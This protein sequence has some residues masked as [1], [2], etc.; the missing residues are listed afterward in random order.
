MT[1]T[2]ILSFSQSP[3]LLA[4]PQPEDRVSFACI[5]IFLSAS[6]TPASV[7]VRDPRF[8]PL[9]GACGSPPLPPGGGVQNS[10]RVSQQPLRDLVRTSNQMGEKPGK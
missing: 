3:L 4:S 5:A 10:H 7:C 2:G 9:S 1:R 6:L 8:V